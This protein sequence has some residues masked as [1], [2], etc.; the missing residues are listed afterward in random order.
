VCSSD[1][2]VSIELVISFTVTCFKL[3]LLT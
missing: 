3:F 2:L 1:L